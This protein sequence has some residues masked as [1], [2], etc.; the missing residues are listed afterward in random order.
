MIDAFLTSPDDLPPVRPRS[1]LPLE[2]GA[3]VPSPV[4][5][6]PRTAI[7]VGVLL[8]VAVVGVAPV[9]A[10]PLSKSTPATESAR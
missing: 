5:G 6:V 4:P 7:A 2:S 1:G 3:A 8:A 9:G 10:A